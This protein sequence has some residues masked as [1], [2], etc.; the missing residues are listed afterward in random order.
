MEEAAPDRAEALARFGAFA[1]GRADAG[2]ASPLASLAKHLELRHATA[3]SRL[4]RRG[5]PCR[6]LYFIAAGYV[7]YELD[8][9]GER[10]FVH[11]AGTGKLAT[12]FGAYYAGTPATTDVTALTPCCLLA[13]ERATLERLYAGSAVLANLGRRI[14]E[15][16]V[17][18]QIAQR[19]EAQALT[20]EERY[21]RI[22][23]AEPQLLRS[24]RLGDLAEMLG[25]AQPTLSRIRARIRE[26]R[27]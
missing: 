14:A 26:R 21:V 15:Q 5:A 12:D 18:A 11:I 27:F 8:A 9:G 17:V 7:K 16:A 2:A 4:V 20:A 1:L 25:I 3:G 24:V 13:V 10:P 19:V 23:E 6:T 22:L